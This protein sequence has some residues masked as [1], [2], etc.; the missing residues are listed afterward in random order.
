[1]PLDIDRIQALCFDIDGTLSDTDDHLVF[2]VTRWLSIV[3]WFFPGNNPRPFARWLIMAIE[4]PANFIYSFLDRIGLDKVF[5]KL[6]RNLSNFTARRGWGVRPPTFWLI[7]SSRQMLDRLSAFYPMAIV[8]TRDHRG[9]HAFLAQYDL[10]GFF[11]AVAHSQ[12]CTHTKPFPDPI[13]WAARELGVPPENCLMIGDTTIDIRAGKAAGAQTVGV[14]CGF[15][16]ESELKRAG[17]DRILPSTVDLV[18]ALG[19]PEPLIQNEV[20]PLENQIS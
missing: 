2:H 15:G 3:R 5:E 12:T 10:A 7:P 16:S 13:L 17:A 8:S 6:R 19:I 11:Q 1:M 20:T 4:S 9:T 18:E 14:L